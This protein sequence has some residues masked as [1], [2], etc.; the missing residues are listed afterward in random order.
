MVE[1]KKVTEQS[2]KEE[3]SEFLKDSVLPFC[4]YMNG[5]NLDD[6]KKGIIVIAVDGECEQGKEHLSLFIKGDK[7]RLAQGI[8]RVMETKAGDIFKRAVLEYI[9]RSNS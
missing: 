5:E 8:S 2:E 9:A 6:T 7:E 4:K 3:T 1:Y